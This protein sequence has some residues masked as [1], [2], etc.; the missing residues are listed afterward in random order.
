M[1]ISPISLCINS[2][3][4]DR[5]SGGHAFLGAGFLERG[6]AFDFNVALQDHIKYL[7]RGGKDQE[8]VKVDWGPMQDLT[9]KEGETIK[10]RIFFFGCLLVVSSFGWLDVWY[11]V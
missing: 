6:A 10:A 2:A 9:L 5:E 8:Q 7:R 3:V 4:E 1:A 11:R